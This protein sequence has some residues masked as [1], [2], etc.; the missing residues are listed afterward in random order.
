MSEAKPPHRP[1]P[2]EIP[3]RVV[4]LAHNLAGLNQVHPYGLILSGQEKGLRGRL[5]G[6]DQRSANGEWLSDRQVETT[7]WSLSQLHNTV[8]ARM[9]R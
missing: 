2:V 5:A 1:I 8:Y 4:R 3:L 9:A 6:Y 7:S